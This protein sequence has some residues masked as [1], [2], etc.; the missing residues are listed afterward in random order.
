MILHTVELTKEG[1]KLVIW[2]PA[3]LN[4]NRVCPFVFRATYFLS[5]PSKAPEIVNMVKGEKEIN[6]SHTDPPVKSA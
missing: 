5:S 3:P 2:E 4:T 6:V 1:Y